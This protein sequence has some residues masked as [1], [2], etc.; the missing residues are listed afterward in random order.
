MAY[1]RSSALVRRAGMNAYISAYRGRRRIGLGDVSASEAESL[2]NDVGALVGVPGAGSMAA[3]IIQGIQSIFGSN[4][5]TGAN[6]ERQAHMYS[7]YEGAMTDPGSSQSVA[8]VVNLYTTATQQYD[9]I[10][11]VQQ[12][13]PQATRTY[14]QQA[15][16]MLATQGWENVNSLHPTYTGIAASG[17]VY[18]ANAATGQESLV[19]QRPLA[20][21][22]PVS[23]TTLLL[24][25]LLGGGFVLLSGRSSSSSSTVVH[26]NR[27]RGNRGNRKRRRQ[28]RGGGR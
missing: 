7:L 14:A 21:A 10:A 27:Y 28:R 23:G 22:S 19:A 26:H 24:L 25:L 5:A 12:N 15:L 11:G 20:S 9:P 17:A 6:A 2:G 1:V 13:N 4:P 16:Q 18:E 3:P 8:D